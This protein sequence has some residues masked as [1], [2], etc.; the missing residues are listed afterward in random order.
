M[1][2]GG[3]S[4]TLIVSS[5]SARGSTVS[6]TSDDG[7][8]TDGNTTDDPTYTA[9][10]ASPSIEVTKTATV[11]DTN[12][13]SKVDIGDIITYTITVSN[14][15]NTSISGISIEDK[16]TTS[17]G[18]QLN[19]DASPTRLST[20][21]GSAVGSL[22]VGEFATYIGLFTINATAFAAERISN[23]A[24]VTA[25]AGG[26]TGNVSDT[27]DDGD[28][29]DGN[30]TDDPTVTIMEPTPS[31]E[32]TKTAILSDSNGSGQTDVGD[33]I[34]FIISI[35]NTGNTN[36]SSLTF[37]DTLVDKNDSALSLTNGPYFVSATQSSTVGNLNLEET[38]YYHAFFTINSQ[39]INAGSVKNSVLATA[40]SPGQSN[41]V[42]DTSDDGDD[43][44]GNTTDDVTEVQVT[45]GGR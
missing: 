36:L 1:N 11:N 45:A 34:K 24:T 22:K 7:D 10:E 41:N 43:T 39:A 4:N 28:D 44:D 6:D 14:T 5:T 20:S 3:V 13:N 17:L 15:G 29:T 37:V 8:D 40:S 42:T 31:I 19:L 38:A 2:S 32:V 9:I 16:I 30:T 25:N 21:N 35:E 33:S 12:S 27:S 18:A 23:T 26:L